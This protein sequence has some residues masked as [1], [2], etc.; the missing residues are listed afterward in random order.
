MI[1]TKIRKPYDDKLVLLCKDMKAIH[2]QI[3]HNEQAH[4]KELEALRRDISFLK[5]ELKKKDNEIKTMQ[6]QYVHATLLTS[7]PIRERAT[8]NSAQPGTSN[9]DPVQAEIEQG[10]SQD[11]Q[12]P[13]HSAQESSYFLQGKEKDIS[14]S[15]PP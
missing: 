12:S 9:Q 7:T 3:K 8:T 15:G 5:D 2:K 13:E 11:E 10:T 4:T 14:D 1:V 6:A